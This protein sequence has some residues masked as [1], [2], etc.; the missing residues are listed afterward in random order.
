MRIGINMGRKLTPTDYCTNNITDQYQSINRW[1]LA[2]I[3]HTHT[4]TH[5]RIT[6]HGLLTNKASGFLLSS[7]G[8]VSG[9]TV[10]QCAV[11]GESGEWRGVEWSG[12]EW[13]LWLLW[14]KAD[15]TKN[16]KW[17]SPRCCGKVDTDTDT[18]VYSRPAKWTPVLSGTT[19]ALDSY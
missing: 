9:V 5:T 4:H 10:M 14:P 17:T 15:R 2:S 18:T 8:D 11:A 19:V 13:C 3:T 16:I 1:P 7:V 6:S 12:V